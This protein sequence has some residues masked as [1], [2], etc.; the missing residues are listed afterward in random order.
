MTI[1]QYTSK[2]LTCKDNNLGTF[3][4]FLGNDISTN[5]CQDDVFLR[6]VESNS[7]D[8][9]LKD[10]KLVTHLYQLLATADKIS[11]TT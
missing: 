4:S 3:I 10:R 7:S 9:D 2:K 11:I 5:L 1:K 8:K 6:C